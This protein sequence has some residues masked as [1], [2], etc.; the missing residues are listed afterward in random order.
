M[1]NEHELVRLLLSILP[2][3]PNQATV[4][5]DGQDLQVS[6][7]LTPLDWS[8]YQ[9]TFGTVQMFMQAR[10]AVFGE[11]AGGPPG[12]FFKHAGAEEMVRHAEAQQEQQAAAAAEGV[13][14]GPWPPQHSEP[15]P[16]QQQPG[17][18]LH[19]DSGYLPEQQHH[20]Q[21]QMPPEQHGAWGAHSMPLML[22]AGVP[23]MPM[24]GMS[25]PMPGMS[26][27]FPMVPHQLAPMAMSMPM[28]P[29]SM[30]MGQQQHHHH[31]H[32]GMH[33]PH[34]QGGMHR[35]GGW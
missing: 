18:G 32:P 33:H 5:G 4:W 25:M 22:P 3:D 8:F 17:Y 28:A 13:P 2:E 12:R 31:H 23:C 24:P 14:A 35:G 10:P 6:I 7:A 19:P 21:Q 1:R 29:P 16:Q 30:L 11:V 34:P 15:P 26:M 20:Q 9:P 27:G